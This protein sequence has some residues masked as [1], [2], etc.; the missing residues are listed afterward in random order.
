MSDNLLGKMRDYRCE[1]EDCGE[2]PA[3]VLLGS[4]LFREYVDLC[5]KSE[6]HTDGILEF[7]GFPVWLAASIGRNDIMWLSVD[8]RR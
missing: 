5:I 8:E 2:K 4:N 1:M 7:N 6:L 3:V